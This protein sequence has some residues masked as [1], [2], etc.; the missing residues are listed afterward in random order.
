MDLVAPHWSVLPWRR[1]IPWAF[2]LVVLFFSTE[3]IVS[4]R[5]AAAID[6]AASR[7]VSDYAPSVV[8]LASARS[9]LH[10][11][12]DVASDYV[13]GNG[14]EAERELVDASHADLDRAVATYESLP[15]IPGERELWARVA[16]DI[17]QVQG[18]LALTV[19]GVEGGDREGARRLASQDLRQAVDKAGT[20]ILTDIELNGRAADDDA[21]LI[22]RRR[23]E[24]LRAAAALAAASATLT[25]FVAFLVY[26]LARQHDALQR[27][28]ANVLREANS[29]L[30][31]FASRLSHD[32][33]SPLAS[34]RFAIDAALKAEDDE[35]IKQTLRRGSQGLERTAR[36][37]YALLEFARSGARPSPTERGD[38]RRIVG[39]VVDEF[40][41]LAEETGARLEAAVPDQ[42]AVACDEGLLTAALSNLVRNALTYLHD[43]PEKR[44]DILAVD[45]GDLV[46]MEVRDTGPGLPLGAE[47]VVF[48][49][50]VR[51]AGATQPGLGLG[52]ATVKRIVESHGGAVGVDSRPGAGCLFWIELPRV[53]V[54]A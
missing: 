46:R 8:A 44:V 23:R 52:L 24:S 41:A 50:Y 21:R 35:T 2:A 33:V 29:E 14:R 9:E 16:E 45:A 28:Y 43:A 22:S 54:P 37:A 10:R 39:E 47:S 40:R 18:T 48:E 3:T 11:L 27:Q 17:H 25:A 19:R 6:T 4:Q 5:L 20:D 51:G 12:Q 42:I 7:I 36:I 38:V 31:I 53:A 49:P 15:F 34:T 26:R 1:T 13:E 30:D 32:I